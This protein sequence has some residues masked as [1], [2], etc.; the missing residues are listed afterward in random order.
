M[1]KILLADMDGTLTP[2]R[3]SIEQNMANALDTFLNSGWKLAI[4]SGS[5][6]DYIKEQMGDWLE[7]EQQKGRVWVMPCN[8]TQCLYKG[9]WEY[10]LNMRDH[11]GN[12]LFKDLLTT[13]FNEMAV[14]GNNS[15]FPFTGD[16]VSYRGST[17]NFCPVG[18]NANDAERQLFKDWDVKNNYRIKLVDKLLLN[19]ELTTAIENHDSITSHKIFN[20]ILYS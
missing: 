1:D 19:N 10:I 4:V 11:V 15:T 6:Y 16:H 5:S 13:L 8:G 18:R 7:R 9:K 14:L 3:K 2:A 17:L 12:D 20:S